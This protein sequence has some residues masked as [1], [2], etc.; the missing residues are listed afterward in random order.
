MAAWVDAHRGEVFSALYEV[1]D[2]PVYSATRLIERDSASVGDP[3]VILSRWRRQFDA[4][5]VFAGDGAVAYADGIAGQGRVL[6][7]PMLASVIGRMAVSRARNGDT[8]DPASIYPLYV[9]RPD[10]ELDRER[11][12]APSQG[13]GS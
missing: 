1:A 9:R 10:A 4:M 11:K 3:A 12:N 6:A 5:C 7:F 13:T 2:Q 8:L